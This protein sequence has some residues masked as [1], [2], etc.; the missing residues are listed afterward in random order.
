MSGRRPKGFCDDDDDEVDPVVAAGYGDGGAAAVGLSNESFR[1][2]ADADHEGAGAPDEGE[3][4]GWAAGSSSAALPHPSAAYALHH[5]GPSSSARMPNRAEFDLP[6]DLAGIEFKEV[7]ATQSAQTADQISHHLSVFPVAQINQQQLR[8]QD[9]SRKEAKNGVRA[10]LGADFESEW[11]AM[12][13]AGG[14]NP[15]ARSFPRS[16][17]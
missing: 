17:P 16:E 4:G 7:C 15:E 6:A 10:A 3:G 8:H 11:A 9:P 12:G 13:R 5:D 2:T 14:C 1:S